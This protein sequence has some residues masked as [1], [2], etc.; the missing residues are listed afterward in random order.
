MLL[1]LFP[2]A[3]LVGL[4]KLSPQFPHDCDV[5]YNDFHSPANVIDWDGTAEA[6]VSQ[7]PVMQDAAAGADGPFLP[8]QDAAA[9]GP[10]SDKAAAAAAH[11]HHTGVIHVPCPMFDY[12]PSHLVSLLVTDTGGHNPSYVYRLLAEYYS[13]EDFDLVKRP[14]LSMARA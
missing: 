11:C 3:V 14:K 6:F 5:T 8:A 4:H 13:K 12:V 2:I 7:R 9:A 1:L 10:T